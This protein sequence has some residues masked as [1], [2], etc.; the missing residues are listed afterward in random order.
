LLPG[1]GCVSIRR[2]MKK[3][4]I[5][6]GLLS[7]GALALGAQELSPYQRMGRDIYRELVETDTSHSRGDTTKAAE[8]L[9]KRFR[10]AG[11]PDADVQ[12]IGPGPTNR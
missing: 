7:L 3:Q 11:F 1:V 10:E 9:A 6:A 5:L 12:V 4:A 2:K 8:L